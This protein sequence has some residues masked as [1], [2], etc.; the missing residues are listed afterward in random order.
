MTRSDD[1]EIADCANLIKERASCDHVTI[2]LLSDGGSRMHR[3]FSSMPLVFPTFGSKPV[4]G[5]EWARQIIE[6]KKPA[7]LVGAEAIEATFPDHDVILANAIH[8]ILNVPVVRGSDCVGS[9][10]CLYTSRHPP[11]DFISLA[12]EIQDTL[13]ASAGHLFLR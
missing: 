2:L 4:P 11:H 9:V 6:L 8:A 5:G 1:L 7:L 3:V 12:G 13:S 10:N